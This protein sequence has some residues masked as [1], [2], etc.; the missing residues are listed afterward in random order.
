MI[1]NGEEIQNDIDNKKQIYEQ[2]KLENIF[3]QARKAEG[4]IFGFQSK[5]LPPNDSTKTQDSYNAKQTPSETETGKFNF[6]F[7][8]QTEVADEKVTKIVDTPAKNKIDEEE[9]SSLLLEHNQTE[10][11]NS[12]RDDTKRD[13][14]PKLTL[15]RRLGATFFN[16]SW[17]IMC[18]PF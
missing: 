10:N 5:I 11:A 15:K 6:S 4:S 16:Q 14:S 8:K 13:V 3:Q 2:T 7:D 18:K 9:K 12:N 1:E 17:I